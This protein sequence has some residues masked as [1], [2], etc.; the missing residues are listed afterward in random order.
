MSWE[1]LDALCKNLEAYDHA[2]SIL[3]VDEAVS[4]PVGGGE[5][6]AEAMS[7]LSAARHE[8]AIAP[9]IADWIADAKASDLSATQKT[10]LAEFE[11]VYISNTCLP[12]TFVRRERQAAMRCEQLWRSLRPTGDWA[13]FAP[14]LQNVIELM[15]EGAALRADKLKLSPY[16]ALVDLYDPGGRSAD[17]TA[18]FE[19]LKKFLIG[20]VPEALA[21]Q[22]ERQAARPLKPFTGPYPI[23]KQKA[24]GQALMAG[25]GFDFTH[26]RL[27]ISTHPFCGG[28]PSDVRLTTRYRTDEF[29]TSLMG[30]LHETGHGLYEQ[31]RPRENGHWPS[32]EARGMSA[33]ESQ[34]LFVERQLALAPEF[35]EW[36]MPILHEH[37]GDSVAGWDA[38]DI[39]ARA[40]L[41]ERGLIRV[42]ADEVTYPLHVILRFELE[43]DIVSGALNAVDLPEAWDAKMQDYLGISTIDDP[44][45]GPMQ[46]VHWPSGAFGYFPSYTLGAMMAAQ[47]WAALEKAVPE[48]RQQMASGDFNAINAWRRDNIWLKGSTCTTPELMRQATGE[49][50]NADHFVAHLKSRYA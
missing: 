24:V 7:T 46:D 45:N 6:R 32:A 4:M 16:D 33:H 38:A 29:L 17:L 40:S 44:A 28:V 21:A 23:E 15:R 3:N 27:D 8:L 42:D 50:L 2:L 10:A 49:P 39:I 43:K 41:V 37:M 30:V 34:S 26:G 25:V 47:Q 22:A 19:P 31:G 12:A 11:R 14:T 48:A 20:F 1:N 13:A 18:V 36:A 9:H 35:W 5:G